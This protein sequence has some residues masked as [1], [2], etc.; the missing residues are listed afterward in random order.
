MKPAFKLKIKHFGSSQIESYTG[1]DGKTFVSRIQGE[2][3]NT[4]IDA[5]GQMVAE[6]ALEISR[7]NLFLAAMF[8]Q[9][10]VSRTPLDEDYYTGVDERGKPT[11]HHADED[12]VRDS[13]VASYNNFKITAKYLRENCGCEFFVFNDR[14]E[15]KKIYQEFLKFLSKGK[16]LADGTATLK[17]VRIENNH[18]RF[19][20]LE[21]GEYEHDGVI[22]KGEHYE[23]GVKGGFSI[24]APVGMLRLTQQEF[25]D[26]AFNIPT[27]DL[28]MD[29]RKW[30]TGLKKKGSLKTVKKLLY[31][32]KKISFKDACEIAKVY[33]V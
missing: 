7:R 23:H 24:Q 8:F 6:K 13:W 32:K 11:I 28:M 17:G 16:G 25:E 2:L 5:T 30:Q 27:K 29:G 20:M 33:S 22:K 18:E 31:G 12:R 14:S 21:Y 26:T 19:P 1:N 3:E 15:V 9:R 4:I 10:V